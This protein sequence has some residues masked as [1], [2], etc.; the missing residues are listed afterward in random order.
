M[1]SVPDSSYSNPWASGDKK[2]DGGRPQEP[3]NGA[4]RP[5]QWPHLSPRVG[6]QYGSSDAAAGNGVPA[7]GT[8]T[9]A[10]FQSGGSGYGS[11]LSN[12]SVALEQ[13]P[14]AFP[15]L[16][17]KTFSELEVFLHD[18][19]TF[20]AF[21][22]ESEYKKRIDDQVSVLRAEVQ[23]LGQLNESRLSTGSLNEI[24]SQL[25]EYQ[26]R[27]VEV[28]TRIAEKEA[29]REA[30]LAKNSPETMYSRLTEAVDH[31]DDAG[32]DIRSRFLNGEIDLSTF[33][34]GYLAERKRYHERYAKSMRLKE[35]VQHYRQN[36]GRG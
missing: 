12:T 25:A 26:S 32:S 1:W 16:E 13:P 34:R 33:S 20:N 18:P 8:P 5:G 35:V 30:Y 11:G 36:H 24:Q 22:R 29:Q 19:D 7:A 2:Q 31:S 17:S 28:R 4:A 10:A 14:A 3:G 15:D 9:G 27:E 23:R 21:I 6:E